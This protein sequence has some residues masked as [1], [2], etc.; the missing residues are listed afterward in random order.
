[1]ALAV[2]M[3]DET[4]HYVRTVDESG[5]RQSHLND[6]LC[7]KDKAGNPDYSDPEV[8]PVLVGGPRR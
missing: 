8:C 5:N 1:V 4:N 2:H 3:Q 6:F 7:R